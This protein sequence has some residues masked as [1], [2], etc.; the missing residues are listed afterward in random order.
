MS[1]DEKLSTEKP[2]E[3]ETT[4]SA[5]TENK[6]SEFH[7]KYV[8]VLVWPFEVPAFKEEPNNVKTFCAELVN[9]G[10]HKRELWRGREPDFSMLQYFNA[11]TR[12]IYPTLEAGAVSDDNSKI[13]QCVLFKYFADDA[14]FERQGWKYHVKKGDSEF[15]WTVLAVELQIYPSGIGLLVIKVCSD[16]LCKD[17]DKDKASKHEDAFAFNDYARRISMPYVP[18]GKDDC[19]SC[20]EEIG[21]VFNGYDAAEDKTRFVRNFKDEVN[22]YV[23]AQGDEAKIDKLGSI[24]A[25]P[26]RFLSELVYHNF[27]N[28]ASLDLTEEEKTRGIATGRMN[29]RGFSDDRMFLIALYRDNERS[30]QLANG[31]YRFD[32]ELTKEARTIRS[33]VSTFRNEFSAKV[34]EVVALMNDEHAPTQSSHAISATMA[35]KKVF[36]DWLFALFFVDNNPQEPTCHDAPTMTRLLE[37][38]SYPRWADYGT[39]YG[40]TNYSMVCLADEKPGTYYPVVK[41][42]LYHYT[43]MACLV[44]AQRLSLM[45]FEKRAKRLANVLAKINDHDNRS[46]SNEKRMTEKETTEKTLRFYRSYVSFNASYMLTE[47]TPQDQGIEIYQLLQKSLLVNQEK[48]SLDQTL[49]ALRDVAEARRERIMQQER[50]KTE[51][52]RS[53]FE[54]YIKRIGF[55]LT[56]VVG[57]MQVIFAVVPEAW[58]GWQKQWWYHL[59]W[60]FT[61]VILIILGCELLYRLGAFPCLNPHGSQK[62]STTK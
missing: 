16:A 30:K 13:D 14:E 17:Q 58:T 38:V 28:I 23:D 35:N 42:F 55:L 15:D 44:Y 57:G 46:D 60:E 27:E 48:Q 24:L 29:L 52:E 40:I 59:A 22:R 37:Q 20:A 61:G 18:G 62:E 7:S 11:A 1:Q 3:P 32:C 4:S 9:R 5:Q 8:D 21:I 6:P 41:P 39:I 10:W 2:T 31:G 25:R 43:Y 33:E 50:E 47:L 34:D 36:I 54:K 19:G 26:A 49:R 51:E 12:Q 45:L 56:V 53:K